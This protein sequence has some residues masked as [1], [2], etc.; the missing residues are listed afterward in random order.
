MRN[1]APATP[2]LSDSSATS[3]RQQSHASRRETTVRR[4]VGFPINSTGARFCLRINGRRGGNARAAFCHHQRL[5]GFA[6]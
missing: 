6:N 4:Q 3:E 5:Q 2:R 1:A